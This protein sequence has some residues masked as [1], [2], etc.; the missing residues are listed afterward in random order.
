MF[1]RRVK[2]SSLAF[3]PTCIVCP[4]RSPWTH[5]TCLRRGGFLLCCWDDGLLLF[6]CAKIDDV[7]DVISRS[8]YMRLGTLPESLRDTP[9][10]AYGV[11]ETHS[12]P[13][14]NLLW[15]SCKRNGNASVVTD[16]ERNSSLSGMI[17]S[18]CSSGMSFRMWKMRCA[19]NGAMDWRIGLLMRQ[20]RCANVW[21]VEMMFS[22]DRKVMARGGGLQT[23]LTWTMYILV[24]SIGDITMQIWIDP[25]MW[26]FYYYC[27]AL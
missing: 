10:R 24:S 4:C 8:D 6:D 11:F 2:A 7:S 3:L 16:F 5:A 15:R 14:Q 26:L 20:G 18:P 9:Q 22:S 21:W 17:A 23:S 13:G 12:L 1:E 19:G 27:G 25:R